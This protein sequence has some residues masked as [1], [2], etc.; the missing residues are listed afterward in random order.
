MPASQILAFALGGGAN[1]LDYADYNAAGWRTAG[2]AAGV[3]PSQHLNTVWRQSSFMS[4][5]LAQAVADLSGSDVEDDGDLAALVVLIK[6]AISAGAGL[7][8]AN[9]NTAIAVG[10]APLIAK[11]AAAGGAGYGSLRI[12]H[13]AAPTTNLTNGDIWTTAAGGLFARINGTTVQFA[14]T[15][16]VVTYTGSGGISKVGA[17]FRL[18]DMAAGT[19]KGRATGGGAGA[20]A[21]L[22][23]AQVNFMLG[24]TGTIVMRANPAIH[25]ATELL[26]DGAAV[27]RATY[28]NLF[29][30]IGTTW[31]P[32][33]GATTFNLPSWRG[34]F[35]RAFD[36]GAGVDPGRVFAAPQADAFEAHTHTAGF[37]DPEGRSDGG[38]N[39]LVPANVGGFAAFTT[40]STGD[41]ETRPVNETFFPCIKI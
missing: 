39:M 27:S 13:G 18:T 17:D 23:P 24:F 21:D 15:T 33:D 12:P 41:T 38:N 29:S 31:G 35:P 5:G 40:G 16:D 26:C 14:Y 34:K 32:G 25:A 9:M 36:D 11:A 7:T 3:A 37:T 30:V 2:F 6:A 10:G 1:V 8:L 20:P 28:A 4:A 19:V 22:T